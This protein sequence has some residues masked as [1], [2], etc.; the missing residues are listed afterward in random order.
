MQEYFTPEDNEYDD[1]DYHKQVRAQS[2]DPVNSPDDR[3][4]T[5]EEIRNCVERVDN[6]KAP[7]EGGIT[8]EIYKQTCKI[9]PD[10]RNGVFP[11]RCKRAKLVPCL[12]PGEENRED[13]SK[14][15]AVSLLNIGG[16]VLE[17]FLIN[18]INRHVYSKNFTKC[19]PEVPELWQ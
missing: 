18:R 14:F 5:I 17:K 4:F 7:G 13:V 12:K 9:F 11:K 15:R 16:K 3:E 19:G 2:Q 8:G 10:L 1:N 6:K